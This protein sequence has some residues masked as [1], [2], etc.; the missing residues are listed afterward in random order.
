MRRD[1]PVDPRAG[2]AVRHVRAVRHGGERLHAAHPRLLCAAGLRR[3]S[4]QHG[5]CAAEHAAPHCPGRGLGQ[6]QAVSGAPVQGRLPRTG[7]GRVSRQEGCRSQLRGVRHGAHP[8]RPLPRTGHA[9]PGD[10]RRADGVGE[11]RRNRCRQV[12]VPDAVRRA[13]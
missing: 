9:R 11:I 4:R 2:P 7:D 8:A 6:R 1:G 5:H 13:A 10:H 3:L 12:R